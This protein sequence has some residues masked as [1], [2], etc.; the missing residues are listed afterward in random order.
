VAT[1]RRIGRNSTKH[2]G[3]WSYRETLK[4]YMFR[5]LVI[6]L[7]FIAFLIS[8]RSTKKIQT[9]IAKKDS[10]ELQGLHA[11]DD[12]I[13]FINEIFQQL[14]MNRINFTTFSAKIN[15]D[16]KTDD[17]NYDVN[18]FVRMYKD[19]V[20]WIS[21]NAILGIEALR[22]LITKDSVK[23]L[24]KQNKEYTSRAVSYLQEVSALPLDLATLQDLIIGNPVF[25]DSN[26]INYHI[27]D[28]E[29]TLLSV[30]EWFKNLLTI[31]EKNNQIEHIKLDDADI[32]RNRTCDLIYSDYEN[33]KGI[34][35][36][37]KRKITITE[38]KNLNIKLE[39]KQFDFN[40]PLT[41]PFSI[42]KNYKTN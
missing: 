33:K 11:K 26:I 32:I 5:S 21:V 24:D 4:V 37:T 41:F 2:G 1:G 13:R 31:N 12:S 34:N 42:P 40:E 38:K 20:I 28:K 15:V 19:S 16:Y 30:G 39:F 9:A 23:L 8:C 36:S 25:L 14:K 10:V 7:I 17:K 27:S 29:V 22:A 6:F 18:A 3:V 35:F